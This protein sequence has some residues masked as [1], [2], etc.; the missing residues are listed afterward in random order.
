MTPYAGMANDPVNL[1]DPDGRFIPILIGALVGGV[2]NL[3]TQLITTKG[4]I[5]FWQGAGAFG[6]GALA[7]AVGVVSG[8]AALTLSGYAAQSVFG[9]AASSVGTVA[10]ASPILGYGNKAIF[11]NPYTFGN[12]AKDL[13]FAALTGGVV[14]AISAPAGT[15]I[16]NRSPK[17]YRS[18]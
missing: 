10:L 6:F 4:H 1:V 13:S 15:N 16:F 14:G 7:G 12:F 3:A 5:S 9:M 2:I 8:G 11:G 17:T 18:T